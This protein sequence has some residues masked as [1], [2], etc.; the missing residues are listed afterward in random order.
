L[1]GDLSRVTT[2]IES[3]PAQF[4]F[5]DSQRGFEVQ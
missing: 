1:M 2:Q 5:G 4:L 3:D